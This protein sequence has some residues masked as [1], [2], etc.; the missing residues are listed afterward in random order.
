MR[1]RVVLARVGT[2]VIWWLRKGL[3][4]LEASRLLPVEYGTVTATSVPA[5]SVRTGAC[6]AP[7]LASAVPRLPLWVPPQAARLPM[8]SMSPLGQFH[9]CMYIPSIHP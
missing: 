7:R 1:V 4:R 9:T 5:A 3:E 6:L 8:P 2:Q